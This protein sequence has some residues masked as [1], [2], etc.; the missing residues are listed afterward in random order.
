MK[1]NLLVVDDSWAMR[2]FVVKQAR[3]V[4]D[5]VG[6]VREAGNG[7][8]ALAA[9]K[10]EPAD[11]VLCDINMPEMDGLE[12]AKAL[13][14][15]PSLESIPVIIISSDPALSREA[16][17]RQLGAIGYIEKPFT[18]VKLSSEFERLFGLAR[19]LVASSK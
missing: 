1:L 16:E 5:V 6:E 11:V 15:D 4:G 19:L 7:K 10:T 14:E 18:P 12:L 17:F 2:K 13:R 8:E 3:A 9:L